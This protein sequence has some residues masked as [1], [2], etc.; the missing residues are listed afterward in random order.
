MVAGAVEGAGGGGEF[1]G[2]AAAERHS[3]PVVVDFQ[4]VAGA[5]WILSTHA[6]TE[7]KRFGVFLV[8]EEAGSCL[9]SLS[10]WRCI[11][12]R[13]GGWGG[14]V[15]GRRR[16]LYFL[17]AVVTA[18]GV[19]VVVAGRPAQEWPSGVAISFM[20]DSGAEA[21]ACPADGAAVRLLLDRPEAAVPL[22]SFSSAKVGSLGAGSFGLLLPG[23]EAC[24]AG[25]QPLLAGRL[26]AP[27]PGPDS[28]ALTRS[29]VGSF[30][31]FSA[32]PS[33]LAV[34][35]GDASFRVAGVAARKSMYAALKSAQEVHERLNVTSPAHF[36]L[37]SKGA[38]GV[39][40]HSIPLES[41]VDPCYLEA[42][43]RHK[44][45]LG[46][47]TAAAAAQKAAVP[48]AAAWSIDISHRFEADPDGYCYALFATDLKSDFL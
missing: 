44:M 2:E 42:A 16:R 41:V 23:G 11:P 25:L 14:T 35:A 19:A 31:V 6:L 7:G 38:L 46:S 1:A 10:D 34:G 39:L 4:R 32:Q 13:R 28:P 20:V 17:D 40:K 24:P 15:G 27:G 47:M 12:L 33:E 18:P 29:A 48:V 8:D 36:R 5:E 43:S 37:F 26:A 9:V 45:V 21:S 30:R 22:T 3:G